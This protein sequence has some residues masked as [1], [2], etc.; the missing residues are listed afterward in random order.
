MLS[1][2]LIVALTIPSLP[3]V[4]LIVT[5][6]MGVPSSL[7]LNSGLLKVKIPGLRGLAILIRVWV[8]GVLGAASM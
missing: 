3:L 6:V 1:V 7:M 2:R 4:R 5:A 8:S